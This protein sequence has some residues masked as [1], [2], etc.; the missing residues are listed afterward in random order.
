MSIG[1]NSATTHCRALANLEMVGQKDQGGERENRGENQL[2][3]TR[4]VWNVP[5]ITA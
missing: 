3:P 2:P 4:H 1:Q 5:L